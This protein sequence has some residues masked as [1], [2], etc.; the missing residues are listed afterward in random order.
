MFQGRDRTHI[1]KKNKVEFLEM[2]TEM[3]NTLDLIKTDEMLWGKKIHKFENAETI[4]SETVGGKEK[5][6]GRKEGGEREQSR[7]GGCRQRLRGK[8]GSLTEGR[9][10]C[11]RLF[12]EI[13]AETSPNLM[14]L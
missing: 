10:G 12:E 13:M 14:K 6:E 7:A 1:Q 5:W 2:K 11:D 9:R 3:K 8:P 4:Q